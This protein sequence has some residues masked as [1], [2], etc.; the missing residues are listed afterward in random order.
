MMT[1]SWPS[2]SGRAS[3]AGGSRAMDPDILALSRA[4]QENAK[5]FFRGRLLAHLCT[6]V[7]SI[8]ALFFENTISYLLAAAA[9]LTELAAWWCRAQAAALHAHP[10]RGIRGALLIK[11]FGKP[12][13]D[14][15][16]ADITVEF[17]QYARAHAD[18]HA[19]EDY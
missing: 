14:L 4:E 10:D 12:K 8:V 15:D 16:A 18:E 13:S 6:V 1:T 17:S 19:D 7:V 9:V 3:S 11:S 5:R 2:G